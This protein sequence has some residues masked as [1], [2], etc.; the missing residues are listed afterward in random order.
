MRG[1]L[2]AIFV[3]LVMIAEPRVTARAQQPDVSFSP[4]VALPTS[5]STGALAGLGLTLAGSSGV[6]LRVTGRVALKNTYSGAFGAATWMPPWGADADAV[7]ALSGRPFGRRNRSASSF[8]FLGVGTSASDTAVIR[9]IHKNWSYG[10]GSMLPLGSVID[11][12]A[13]SRWRIGRFVLPT[14][15][16]KPARSQEFRL[17]ISFHLPGEAAPPARRRRGS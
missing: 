1:R 16:P 9:S 11:L 12:F 3:L 7:F 13:E 10:V 5:P 14:A 15:T 4:F 17:G 6:A 8:V 2:V